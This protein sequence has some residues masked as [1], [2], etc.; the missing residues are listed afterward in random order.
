MKEPAGEPSLSARA[1]K[2]CTEGGDGHMHCVRLTSF[3]H[4]TNATFGRRE[5]GWGVAHRVDDVADAVHNAQVKDGFVLAPHAVSNNSAEDGEHVAVIAVV[6]T[7]IQC[8]YCEG[9]NARM[10]K[11]LVKLVALS[12][13]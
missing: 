11:A 7:E 2:T 3:A 6:R 4:E 12:S 9:S 10:L 8:R 5:G 1:L 13:E